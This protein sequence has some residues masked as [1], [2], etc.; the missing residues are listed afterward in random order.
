M[1]EK[2]LPSNIFMYVKPQ[3]GRESNVGTLIFICWFLRLVFKVERAI[4]TRNTRF[5]DLVDLL[6]RSRVSI[7]YPERFMDHTCLH[8]PMEPTS[9]CGHVWYRWDNRI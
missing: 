7:D 5:P 3:L 8:A 6:F 9:I 4:S 1:V 2:K